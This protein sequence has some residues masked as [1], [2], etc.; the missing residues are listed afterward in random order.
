MFRARML[1]LLALPLALTIAVVACASTGSGTQPAMNTPAAAGSAPAATPT[2][3]DRSY[4]YGE[5][6]GGSDGT[7]TPAPT[8]TPTAAP[9]ATATPAPAAAA[10]PTAGPTSGQQVEVEVFNFGFRPAEITISPG[11]TVVW[12]NTSPTTHT[13]T[14]KERRW[15]SGFFEQG[16]RFQMTFDTPGEYE[17]WC[18]LHP[19]MEGKVIVR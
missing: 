10:T 13:V 9:P 7:S 15:D 1:A 2:Q 8:A 14:D 5:P 16:Q 12:I 6:Y 18:L 4:G 3:A 17:Y 11:T 19:D